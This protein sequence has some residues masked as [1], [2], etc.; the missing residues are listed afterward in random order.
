MHKFVQRKI[1]DTFLSKTGI[2][3]VFVSVVL[4]CSSIFYF[5]EVSP[6]FCFFTLSLFSFKP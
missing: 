4:L 3:T 6:V 2:L 5:G 1:Y